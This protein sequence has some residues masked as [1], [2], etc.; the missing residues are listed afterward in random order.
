[1]YQYCYIYPKLKKLCQT[2]SDRKVELVATN[3]SAIYLHLLLNT[4][5]FRFKF[6]KSDRL[7]SKFKLEARRRLRNCE[8]SETQRQPISMLYL[9]DPVT[10]IAKR[11]RPTNFKD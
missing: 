11:G 3:C 1:M 4:T 9:K 5:A 7:K 8:T 2:P 6:R 10:K